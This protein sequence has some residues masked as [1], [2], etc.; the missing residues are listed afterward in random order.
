MMRSGDAV[1]EAAGSGGCGDVGTL[2]LRAAARAAIVLAL[3]F[4]AGSA[5]AEDLAADTTVE[6]LR[7]FSLEDLAKLTVVSVSK[8]DEPLSQAPASIFV[9][10]ADDIRRSGA[11]SLPEALRLAPNLQVARI[12]SSQYAITARGM[13]SAESSNK[14]LVLINGRSVYEPIGSG[15]LWQQVNVAMATI[16]RIEVVSGPGGTLWGANAVNG[17]INVIT[18]QAGIEGL[19]LDVGGGD[20]DRNA[21]ATWGGKLGSASVRGTVSAFDRRGFDAVSP[22]ETQQDGYKGVL[23]NL[24]IDGGD[25]DLGFSLSANAYNNH[26]QDAD[27]RLWGGSVI[28]RVGKTL[29]NGS[30]LDVE[31]YVAR[32]D[33]SAIDTHERRDTYNLQVQDSMTVGRHELVFGGEARVWR[34]YFLS[35][36]IFHFANPR[37][38]ISIGAVFAQDVVAL[39]PDLKLTVG[40]KLEDN[41][42][43]GLDWMPNLRLAWTPNDESLVWA[44][45]S[46]AVRTP[47]R[48]ERELIAPPILLPSPDFQSESLWAFETGYRVQ[49]TPRTSLSVTAYYDAYDDLR[50]DQF[51]LPNLFPIVL[52]NGGV[53]E[54]Y[55]VE[56]WA[57]FT[58]TDW[59]RLRAGANA[60][61]RDY[62]TKAGFNDLTQLQ[63]AGLDPNYQAQLRSD[64]QLASNLDLDLALRRVGTVKTVTGA[65]NAP[66]YTE[67]DLRLAWRV[68]EGLELSLSGFNLL[69]A[70]HLEID[71]S[72]TTPA[73]TIPRSVYVGL[74][75]GF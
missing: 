51:T 41:S 37:A 59:W 56:A 27:G 14:L 35:T 39:R 66:A 75:W 32:D 29:A 33:R 7:D 50:T 65:V 24:R 20:F 54:T 5:R 18:K 49:P 1:N 26:M 73:R 68:R 10:T 16:E 63:S 22:S 52:R 12:N 34:E 42:Y 19:N 13:N 44:A 72:S 17:V 57:T 31:A 47:N 71:D 21:T 25:K 48:I 6:K 67:A 61:H 28:G 9:I 15:V 43:S 40:L 69:H 70:R 8:R 45:V 2:K 38:T 58:P 60:L 62:R 11:T 55:G 46:R 4:G 74:R 23:G 64:M 36:N 30:T 3:T 53:G